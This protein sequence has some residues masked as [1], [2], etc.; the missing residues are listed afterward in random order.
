MPKILN[1]IV[2]LYKCFQYMLKFNRENMMG[3]H[4]QGLERKQVDRGVAL[5]KQ[6]R[7]AFK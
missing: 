1:E 7:T 6:A 5:N 4:I 3:S 2:K